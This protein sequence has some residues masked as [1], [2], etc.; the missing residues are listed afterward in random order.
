MQRARETAAPFAKL[1]G[2]APEIV[3]EVSEISTPAGV[4]DRVLWLRGVMAGTWDEAGPGLVRW[5]DE[6]GARVAALP[7]GTAVFSHF[8]AINALAGLFASDAKVTVFRPGHCSI[9]RLDRD[10][11]GLCVVEYGSEASTRVL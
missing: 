2:K 9:T 8:V 5:R 3:P 10:E 1:V 11:N 7:E 6:M 4:T